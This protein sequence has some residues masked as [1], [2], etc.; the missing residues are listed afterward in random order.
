[1]DVWHNPEFMKHVNLVSLL[2]E[3][4]NLQEKSVLSNFC[5]ESP[6]PIALSSA[7]TFSFAKPLSTLSSLAP[8]QSTSQ[9]SSLI[10]AGMLMSF[11]H[12]AKCP[13]DFPSSILS[14]CGRT[15]RL[16]DPSVVG[17]SSSNVSCPPMQC[18]IHHEDRSLLSE[19]EWKVIHHSVTI[20]IPSAWC[21]KTRS[22]ASNAT[23]LLPPL[24]PIH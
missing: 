22:P 16:T 18:A 23:P 9:V 13:D 24:T 8:S 21:C 11:P 2:Q 6:H 4:L 10:Q 7:H 20:V 3:L 5:C 14:G 1:M 15:A 19:A 17:M 12:K